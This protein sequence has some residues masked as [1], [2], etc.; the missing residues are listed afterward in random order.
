MGSSG[1]PPSGS[2]VRKDGAAPAPL[3]PVAPARP[4]A[5][6]VRRSPRP[7]AIP[8]RRNRTA[9]P[10]QNCVS[11]LRNRS[12]LSFALCTVLIRCPP[13]GRRNRALR[14]GG[15]ALPAAVWKDPL[16]SVPSLFSPHLSEALQVG[17]VWKD[18]AYSSPFIPESLLAPPERWCEV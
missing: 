5:R 10:A 17:R 14:R 13:T 11:E 8:P 7:P 2:A 9:T 6:S 15:R 1:S 16:L 4:S 3:P 18:S 12:S